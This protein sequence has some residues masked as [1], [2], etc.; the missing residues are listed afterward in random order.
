MKKILGIE[1]TFYIPFW[2][3]DNFL[4]KLE[5]WP[6]YLGIREVETVTVRPWLFFS[7]FTIIVWGDASAINRFTNYMRNGE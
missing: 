1:S 6:E 5:T 2:S 3:E 4:A 7:S